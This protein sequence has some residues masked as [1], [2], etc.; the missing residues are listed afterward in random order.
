MRDPAHHRLAGWA[1]GGVREGR[2]VTTAAGP[3]VCGNC[4]SV[5]RD[6]D[7]RC[8][9]CRTP[10][11]LALS[12]D[13][14]EPARPGSIEVT[15][16]QQS[17][18]A[19]SL[20]ARYRD[21]D[22][23]ALLV[24]AAVLV[25][26]AITLARTVMTILITRSVEGLG[27][28]STS[29]A[30]AAA[31]DQVAL[32]GAMTYVVL[33][34]WAVGL[35]AWGAWLARVIANVP[36]LGGGWTAETPRF[37]FVSTLIPGGNLYWTTSTMRQAIVALSPKDKAGLGIITAWWLAV[38]PT[39][40]LLLNIGP[41]RWLR[42]IIETVIAAVLLLLSGGD[43]RSLLDAAILVELVGGVLLVAAAALAVVL[44]Q[45]LQR[46]QAER[47]QALGALVPIAT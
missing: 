40:I 16:G 22:G 44:I 26:T 18:T 32:L 28:D 5:N 6:G 4:R 14:R 3:W 23:L 17:M 13:S 10:R 46:L 24:Q 11:A 8:Y 30:I 9:S 15:P 38:T 34:A 20:G 33:G 31:L 41:L 19:R 25:V 2:N 36:A 1:W 21:S 43:I 47:R 45:S 7:S 42:T 35:V 27:P 39:L 29:D 37:A 12:P